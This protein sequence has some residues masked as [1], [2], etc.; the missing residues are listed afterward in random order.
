MDSG[1]GS[2]T[3][4]ENKADV[5][6][7]FEDC[8]WLYAFCRE[9]LFQDH[10]KEIARALFPHEFPDGLI[11]LLEV[12]CGPGFYSRRFAVRF[13]ALHVLGVDQSSRL[14]SWAQGRASSDA[15]TNCHFLEGD[16]E[17][18]SSYVEEVD[19]VICSRLLLVVAN[20]LSVM[21]EMFRVLKPG[22]RLFLAEP[23]ANFKTQLPLS[24]M[25]FVTRLMPSSRRR[26]FPLNA[27][28]LTS[29]D[30]EELVRSQPWGKVSL[31]MYGDYQCAIC[32]KSAGRSENDDLPGLLEREALA[33][34][35]RSHA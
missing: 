35:S 5:R 25:R 4:T 18:L 11:S 10:T 13:P 21:T 31:Q 9:H 28:I 19:A 23:T 33:S 6:N 24:A 14:I 7:L 29:R 1:A 20:R 22:G 30:F 32:E 26:T 16:V 12:G 2:L 27:E 17:C 3:R 8:A 15:L 34:V